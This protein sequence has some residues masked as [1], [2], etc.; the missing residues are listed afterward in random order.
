MDKVVLTLSQFTEPQNSEESCPHPITAENP[1]YPEVIAAAQ[2]RRQ[3]IKLRMLSVQS[4]LD[5][6]GNLMLVRPLFN[7]TFDYRK[8][9]CQP[10]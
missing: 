1:K 8:I 9:D 3:E 6:E 7:L 10:M 4:N 2:A 5:Q